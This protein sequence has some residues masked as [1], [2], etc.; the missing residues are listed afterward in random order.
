MIVG[1]TRSWAVGVH[2][3]VIA[4]IMVEVAGCARDVHRRL[5]CR[6]ADR[7]VR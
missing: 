6:T 3:L 4:V 5:A 7:M 2:G 1:S